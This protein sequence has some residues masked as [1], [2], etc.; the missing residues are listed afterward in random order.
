MKQHFA[1][2]ALAAV[3]LTPPVCANAL[4]DRIDA[5]DK[6]AV[7]IN[8]RTAAST[9]NVAQPAA[10]TIFGRH[11]LDEPLR[12]PQVCRLVFD[13]AVL[14][15]SK[16]PDGQFAVEG[17][18][19]R[20]TISGSLSIVRAPN[21]IRLRTGTMRSNLA[22]GNSRIDGVNFHG[23]RGVALD[24]QC[25]S[26]VLTVENCTF[27]GCGQVLVSRMCDDITLRHCS[28][29]GSGFAGPPI[30]HSHG[31]LLLDGGIY[32]PLP[33]ART[34]SGRAWVELTGASQELMFTARDARFGG[35]FG[36]WAV[37]RNSARGRTSYP[38]SPGVVIALERC[39]VGNVPGKGQPHE[40]LVILDEPPN[41]LRIHGCHGMVLPKPLVTLGDGFD[42]SGFSPAGLNN[43]LMVDVGLHPRVR[44]GEELPEEIKRFQP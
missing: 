35:E 5:A 43:R 20:V 1:C 28:V 6:A 17:G 25:R 32:T 16:L 22:L 42:S 21:G 24:V 31:R 12:I 26:N 40:S 9:T 10:V 14:D 30:T 3:L 7:R 23:V 4:Q 11:V 13:G 34:D 29:A 19:H 38:S 15:G 39:N 27:D 36:G 41:Q 2:L 37:V 44:P 8:R 18:G 33:S